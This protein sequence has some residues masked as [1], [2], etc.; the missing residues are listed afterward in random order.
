MLLGISGKLTAAIG[1]PFLFLLSAGAEGLAF[2]YGLLVLK[3]SRVNLQLVFQQLYRLKVN[4]DLKMP[5]IYL[6]CIF[7]S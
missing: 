5:R 2:V 3:E 1:Y 7:Q 6:H 4:L